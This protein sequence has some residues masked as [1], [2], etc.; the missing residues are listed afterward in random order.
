MPV[1]IESIVPSAGQATDNFMVRR[2]AGPLDHTIE[3]LSSVST[4]ALLSISSADIAG[5]SEAIDDRVAAL[6]VPGANVTLTYDDTANTLTVA[7]SGGG[8][9]DGDKGDITVSGGGATWTI[10]AGVITLAK[11]AN[12]A[13]D[14]FLGRDTA[15]S[16]AP[17]VL[18]AATAR[19]ILNVA[20]G[21]TA[22]AA[23]AALRDR[24]THTGTQL[25]ATI[26]DFSEAVDDRAAALLV[27]GTNITLT[28]NDAGGSLTIDAAGGG[29]GTNLSYTAATRVIASDTGTDATL[30]LMSS[31][32]AGLVPASGGG[33]T[34]FLRADG[35]FAAPSGGGAP[36]GSSGEVQYNN[37]G[38]FGGAADVEIEGGQ[39]RLPYITA[40][41]APA[42]SGLKLFGRNF[43]D[44]ALAYKLP[45]G[46]SLLVQPDLADFTTNYT[47]CTPGG[48]A[49]NGNLILSYTGTATTGSISGNSLHTMTIRIEYL[50]TVASTTAVVGWRPNN[51][52]FLYLRVGRAGNAPGGFMHRTLWGLATG[53]ATAT[54]RAFAGLASNTTAPTDVEPSTRVNCVGMGWDAADTNIQMMHNDGAGTCTKIDL[55]ASFPVPTTDRADLYEVQLY[56]PNSLTQSVDYRVIRYDNSSGSKTIAAEATGTITTNLPGT[57]TFMSAYGA[58]SVGGTSSVIGISIIG[59][60]NSREY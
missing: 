14:S 58:A 11:M 22:N 28:Y 33:T 23:D 50:I 47:V 31:G 44:G 1:T 54:H 19:T 49:M 39:L 16:G 9:T 36:G 30:P 18:S 55:G 13:T 29:A 45:S 26:S 15:G 48:T 4:K 12:M 51:S 46:R 60:W 20:D 3:L 38:A 17:E 8:V 56:S 32:D 43:G 25:A 37:A 21:A 57:S 5:L 35:T 7:A 2:G 40:P 6:L 59:I 34:N 52:N 27:A 53:G 10:D 24:A 41:S 42:A